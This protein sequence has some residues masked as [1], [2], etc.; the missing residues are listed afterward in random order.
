MSPGAPSSG[1]RTGRAQYRRPP[2]PS[3]SGCQPAQQQ[4]ERGAEGDAARMVV[5][6]DRAPL[7]AQDRTRSGLRVGAPDRRGPEQARSAP[8][9]GRQP[10]QQVMPPRLGSWPAAPRRAVIAG[11]AIDRERQTGA[12]RICRLVERAVAAWR[13]VSGP[14]GG[15]S[16]SGLGRDGCSAA[17]RSAYP[18]SQVASSSARIALFARAEPAPGRRAGSPPRRAPPP[19]APAPGG[20][21][22]GASLARLAAAE[23]NCRWPNRAGQPDATMPPLRQRD[24]QHGHYRDGDYS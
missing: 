11:P 17:T 22:R 14:S 12:G 15:G 13:P 21:P 23:G 3:S 19:G 9:G 24:D 10:V 20:P 4:A 7:G 6:R 5:P 1:R 8:V 16:T 2:R 18:G